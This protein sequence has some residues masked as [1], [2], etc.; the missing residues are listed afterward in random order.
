[1]PK[2]R[3]R[4]HVNPLSKKYLNPVEPPNWEKIY[5]QPTQ[6]LHLDIGCARGEFLLRMATLQPDWNFLGL[7]IREPL[8]KQANAFVAELG[9]TNLHYL[10]CNVNNSLRP[11]LESLPQETLQRVT[12]QFPDPW[13][14]KRH[15]KRRL[16]QPK[17][18]DDLA[19]YLLAAGTIFLQSD[20]KDVAQ[21]MCE[22]FDEHSAFQ[23]Q[24]NDW[25]D[26]N[27]LPVPTERETGTLARGEPVYRALFGKN[28]P[29]P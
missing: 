15:A 29:L 20:V 18:V 22:R 3:V 10:F 16:V 13:F 21:E 6:P 26:T 8:V 14:K 5:T 12:I 25:L 17:L 24:G 1:M 11:L 2:V 28:S 19:T 4:Q 23:R 7:E 27:P 9:L